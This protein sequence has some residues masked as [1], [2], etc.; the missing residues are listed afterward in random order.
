MK[1]KPDIISDVQSFMKS[2]VILSAAELDF[3]SKLDDSFVS[4]KELAEMSGLDERATTRILDCLV[5]YGLLEKD[6]NRYRT[7]EKGSY[8]SSLHG[9]SALPMI[10]HMNVI[11]NNWSRLTDVIKKGSNPYLKPV[12]DTE[13][14]EDRN[15]FIGAMHVAARRI[16]VKIADAYDLSSFK[17]LFDIGGGS[18]AYSIAFLKKNPRINAVIFDLEGVIPITKEKVRENNF[19]DRVDF[20][21][22]DFYVDDL[23]TGCDI[24]LLSAII[25]QNSP[26]Q[27]VELYRKIY[28]A[29]D[30]GGTLIIRDH[31]M[32]ESRTNPPAGALFALNMLVNTQAGDTYTFR[33]VKDTLKAAG[34]VEV[35]LVMAGK[36]MDCLVEAIKPNPA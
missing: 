6:S 33:E 34:F 18:G 26:Q 24:A 32:D 13:S 11:W 31:I 19:Q 8:L 2:R 22:G 28:R 30:P 23:P 17:K 3:F 35:K 21:V 5:T 20:V 25:H 7:T 36:E 16:A 4:A 15:A 10:K 1:T 9:E 12:V 14:K 27:N 29:L